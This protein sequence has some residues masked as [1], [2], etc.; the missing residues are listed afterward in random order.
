MKIFAGFMERINRK[1]LNE[2]INRGLVKQDSYSAL[3]IKST[4]RKIFDRIKAMRF[5]STQDFWAQESSWSIKELFPELYKNQVDFIKKEFIPYLD[6]SKCVCDLACADG[7]WTFFISPFVK[8]VD[9]IEYSDLM[10]SKAKQEAKSKSILN[11]SFSQ[12]D[13]KTVVYSH[14]YD[15]FIM[16]GLLS[17]FNDDEDV[18]LILNRIHDALKNNGRIMIKDSLIYDDI[19][20]DGYYFYNIDSGYESYYRTKKKLFDMFSKAGFELEKET[21]LR[22]DE[23]IGMRVGNIGAVFVKRDSYDS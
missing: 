4:D 11:V 13:A 9:G 19:K 1:K 16:M 7:E 3:W 17:Y 6:N 20:E 23:R 15:D 2:W 14:P 10:V 5:A 21:V 8:Q 22:E 18:E 12:G